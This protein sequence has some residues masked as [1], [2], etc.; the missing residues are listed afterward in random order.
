MSPPRIE[1]IGL[2]GI[3]EVKAGDSP[4]ALIA[5]AA[6]RSAVAVRG[7]DVFAVAQK[8]VS[9][10]EGQTV[11]LTTVQPSPLAQEWGRSHGKDPRLIETVLG[12]TRRIVRMDRGR[13]IV[14]THSGFICANAGVDR[15]N[16]APETATTLPEDCDASAR[17]IRE[18]LEEEFGVP[19]GV[20]VTDT[21]GRPWRNGLTNVALGVSG[22]TP[23]LDMAGVPDDAGRPL[24]S[25][26]IALA[27]ELASAAGLMMGKTRRLP[28]VLIRGVRFEPSSTA[29]G[30]D[31]LRP[32]DEDLFR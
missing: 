26:V 6:R 12:R 7:G 23:L 25:T 14:E 27:D 29:S 20:I 31:L 9:K 15:S 30:R 10:A 11:D 2:P 32:A 16:T 13:L 22:L 18:R 24:Q 28:A 17:R 3:P 1:I 5:E 8:M 19:L 4:G 21:F